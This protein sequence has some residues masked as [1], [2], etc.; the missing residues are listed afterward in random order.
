MYD[1]HIFNSVR[2][3]ATVK[4]CMSK[5]GKEEFIGC[6]DTHSCR[7]QM[8]TYFTTIACRGHV[9]ILHHET[10]SDSESSLHKHR[11]LRNFKLLHKPLQTTPRQI[12]H[13]LIPTHHCPRFRTSNSRTTPRQI[14]TRLTRQQ[15]QEL[16]TDVYDELI[17]RRDQH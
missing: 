9:Y 2:H 12:F 5:P 4:D 10:R 13:L 17:R 14:L 15:F 11:L 7:C 6:D 8:G 16:S 3:R 1:L